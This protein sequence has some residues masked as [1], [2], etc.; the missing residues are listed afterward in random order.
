MKSGHNSTCNDAGSIDITLKMIAA[1]HSAF[2]HFV[3]TLQNFVLPVY[4]YFGQHKGFCPSYSRVSG[5]VRT[6]G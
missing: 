5:G 3:T 6:I 4:V 2:A 1:Y